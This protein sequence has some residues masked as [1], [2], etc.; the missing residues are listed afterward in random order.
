MRRT[1]VYIAGP[2]TLGDKEANVRA[3]IDAATVLL[4]S[5]FAPYVPHLTHYWDA[6][7]PRH[8]ATWIALDMQWL[9]CCDVLLR[10]PGPS[11]GADG[12]VAA[13]G[14]LGIPVRYSAEGIVRDFVPTRD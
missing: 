5:G 2:Y 9:T 7:H 11:E 3:S 10:L 1:R 13:A 8:Y 6:V 14:A 4:D 12:E